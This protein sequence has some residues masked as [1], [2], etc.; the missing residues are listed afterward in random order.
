MGLLLLLAFLVLC[1][2]QAQRWRY[3]ALE[4]NGMLQLLE[5]LQA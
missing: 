4:E 1:T 2:V 3:K 5:R